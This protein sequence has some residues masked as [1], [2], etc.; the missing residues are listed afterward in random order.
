MAAFFAGRRDSRVNVEQSATPICIDYGM[1]GF[2]L[3][4]GIGW[5]GATGTVAGMINRE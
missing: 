3:V 2:A 1:E 5:V 4:I